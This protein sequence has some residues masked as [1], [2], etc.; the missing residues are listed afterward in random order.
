MDAPHL[1]HD[2]TEVHVGLSKPQLQQLHVPDL[3]A[4]T[5]QSHQVRQNRPP[6]PVTAFRL[7]LGRVVVELVQ[8][9]V[10]QHSAVLVDENVFAAV[11]ADQQADDVR[12]APLRTRFI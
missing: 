1:Q 4:T 6:G 8:Q 10:G 12:R 7:L 2:L 3:P 9:S 11:D 5:D